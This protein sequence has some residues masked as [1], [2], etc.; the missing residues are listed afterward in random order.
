MIKLV[1]N[2]LIKAFH[3]KAVI[4]LAI[5][6]ALFGALVYFVNKSD[7]DNVYSSEQMI[8]DNE[9]YLKNLDLSSEI[10]RQ[11]YISTCSAIESA[12]F[13]KEYGDDNWRV[14]VYDNVAVYED[15]TPYDLVYSYC[16]AT[17][18]NDEEK[19]EIYLSI[20]DKFKD[21]IK[22][23]NWNN[24]LN[25]AIEAKK[26]EIDM[27]KEQLK[28][29]S[30]DLEEK[31]LKDNIRN[32]ELDLEGLNY[33]SKYNREF[34]PH[35]SDV[36]SNYV[37]SAKNYKSMDQN[38]DNYKTIEEKQEFRAAKSEYYLY[39]YKVEHELLEN[40]YDSASNL[41]A[42]DFGSQLLFVLIAI[43]II[44]GSI[45]SDE[46]NKGTIKQ[47]LLRPFTRNKIL[48]SKI[49]TSL[50]M[51][52]LFSVYFAFVDVILYGLLFGFDTFN[53]PVLYFDY[54]N[55]VVVSHNFITAT[56][57]NFAC[58]LPFYLI[59]L[60]VC[61]FVGVVSQNSTFAIAAGFG[62]YVVGDIVSAF[63]DKVNNI[64][65]ALIPCNSWDLTQFLYGGISNSKY[66][67]LGFC[68]AE[69]IIIIL[70][71]FVLSFVIFKRINIKNQ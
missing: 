24:Y 71:L 50:I 60:G 21:E 36:I 17:V 12:K 51:F 46:F 58:L 37:S 53:V 63:I 47:L 14:Y 5:F 40:T 1:K 25:N 28:L 15:Q 13:S 32:V 64:W 7:L 10:G 3:K 66:I 23:D 56:L 2:E 42:I 11:D 16:E 9:E 52:V 57:I 68:L 39:K 48:M 45:V 27:Y 33:R 19:K 65:V 8:A 67:T 34:D 61:I 26:A 20:I 41:L 69:D 49:I 29:V 31:E 70:G 22:N 30:N 38:E 62:V 55:S 44:A 4:F 6:I 35:E 18:N 43:I 59:V 54:A